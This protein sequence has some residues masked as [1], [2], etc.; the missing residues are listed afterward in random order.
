MSEAQAA[1]AT[2]EQEKII[3]GSPSETETTFQEPV[4]E[5]PV[6]E[7]VE[8]EKKEDAAEETPVEEEKKPLPAEEQKPLNHNQRRYAQ[9]AAAKA[10]LEG[11]VAAYENLLRNVLG[12]QDPK[13]VIQGQVQS[14]ANKPDRGQY[15][16]DAS[17]FEALAEYKAQQILAPQLQNLQTQLQ[18][19]AVAAQAAV[20]WNKNAERVKQDYPDFQERLHDI[21]DIEFKPEI[22][23]ALSKSTYGPDIAY[24]L[25][26]NPDKAEELARKPVEDALIEIG[27]VSSYIEYDEANKKKSTIPGQV[28]LQKSP[29]VKPITPPRGRSGSVAGSK[30]VSEMTADE[31][32]RMRNKQLAEKI[33]KRRG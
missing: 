31:Y 1:N 19:Q 23:R 33:N 16:D 29:T 3:D 12:G 7:V 28:G 13:Q 11:Q 9:T 4:E 6:D 21:D 30:Q 8:E 32:V 20:E 18:Q 22:Q 14:Q 15:N 10:R 26:V 17:F 2:I 27:R 5:K 25:A 24:Y